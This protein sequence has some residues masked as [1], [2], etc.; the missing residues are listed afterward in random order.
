MANNNTKQKRNAGVA[1]YGKKRGV[2]VRTARV[3]KTPWLDGKPN[4]GK[5]CPHGTFSPK[6]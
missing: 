1:G 6:K 4:G 3:G 2:P 5:P